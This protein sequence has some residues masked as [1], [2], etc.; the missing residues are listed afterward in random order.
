MKWKLHLLF[1]T[2]E[3]LSIL[4]ANVAAGYL[5]ALKLLDDRTGGRENERKRTGLGGRESGLR[6]D[7]G[8]RHK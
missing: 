1:F 2:A 6:Q 8:R 5:V 7:R 3:A 4:R